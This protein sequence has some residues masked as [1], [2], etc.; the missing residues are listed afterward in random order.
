MLGLIIFSLCNSIHSE[1]LTKTPRKRIDIQK[2]M[3]YPLPDIIKRYKK[4]YNVTDEDAK[5]HERELKRY[6]ILVAENDFN[7]PMV[8]KEIDNL[9]HTFLL[10]TKDY[11][12]Y[13]KKIL[14]K[15]I[16]HVPKTDGT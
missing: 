15:F 8:S 11:E 2:A 6:L 16:H 9:W 13:C 4:D 7:I 10:F 5:K 12:K 3:D 1:Q 14:K